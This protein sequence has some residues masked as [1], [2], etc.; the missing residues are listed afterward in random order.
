MNIKVY[1]Y[2]LLDFIILLILTLTKSNTYEGIIL[3]AFS[4]IVGVIQTIRN[5]KQS[6]LYL[7]IIILILDIIMG[8]AT[9][10]C[11]IILDSFQYKSKY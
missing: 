6:K 11:I 1:I 5:W 3:I 9:I 4:S 10:L 2:T 7:N 8:I